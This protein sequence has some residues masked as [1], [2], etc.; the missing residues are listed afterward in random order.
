MY[1]KELETLEKCLNYLNY[2]IY[3]CKPFGVFIFDLDKDGKRIPRDL[4]TIR[5]DFI[6]KYNIFSKAQKTIE[7]KNKMYEKVLTDDYLNWIYNKENIDDNYDIE[8]DET[9]TEEEKNNRI[10]LNVLFNKLLD[11]GFPYEDEES[12]FCS[13]SIYFSIKDKYFKLNCTIGLGISDKLTLLTK[14]E[15]K[16]KCKVLI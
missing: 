1:K 9:L 6:K 14:D 12:D 10:A 8:Y 2:I 7:V 13:A 11:Q 3:Q 4:F 15:D 5:E 16:K